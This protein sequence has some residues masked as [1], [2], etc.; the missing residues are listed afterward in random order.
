V[1]L[2]AAASLFVVALNQPVKEDLRSKGGARFDLWVGEAALGETCQPG[3]VLQAELETQ[4]GSVSIVEIAPSGTLT[5]L[6]SNPALAPGRARLPESW[7]LDGELGLERFVAIF[8]PRP[9]S[10]EQTRALVR[11]LRSGSPGAVILER[12][13]IKVLPEG[14]TP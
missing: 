10:E 4:G 9:L 13:C 5:P 3:N 12:R 14:G 6:Y 7:T 2:A 1:P 8:S 11:E